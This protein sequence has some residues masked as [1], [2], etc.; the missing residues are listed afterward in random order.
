MRLA[1]RSTSLKTQQVAG[2]CLLF[3]LIKSLATAIR[4][5]TQ[6]LPQCNAAAAAKSLQSCSTLSDPMHCSLPSSSDHGI[7]QAR[8]LEW[9]AIAFCTIA[10]TLYQNQQ[11]LQPQKR[12]PPTAQVRVP[13]ARRPFSFSRSM[14]RVPFLSPQVADSSAST[15]RS[16][17]LSWGAGEV[18]SPC[19]WRGG[20]RHCSRAMVGESGLETC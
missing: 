18:G 12:A 15:A 16:V 6:L 14:P 5:Q 7:V 17:S 4:N 10:K 3:N 13:Q 19:E 2:P 11:G 20:A 9:V 8:V 1:D